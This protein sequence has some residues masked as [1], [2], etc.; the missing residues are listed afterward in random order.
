M[1]ISKIRTFFG[2]EG[3][4]FTP[5]LHTGGRRGG[6]NFKKEMVRKTERIS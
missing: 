5:V 3:L 4:L 1:T 6:H 2:G